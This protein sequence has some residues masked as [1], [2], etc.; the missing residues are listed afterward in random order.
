MKNGQTR[1]FPLKRKR[2][3][4]VTYLENL[5][6]GYYKTRDGKIVDRSTTNRVWKDR[7]NREG[8]RVL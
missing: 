3:V 8:E 7:Y 2:K 5:G 4:K 6:N 1:Y